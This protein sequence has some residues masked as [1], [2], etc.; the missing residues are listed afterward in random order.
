MA[1]NNAAYVVLLIAV[2]TKGQAKYP[3]GAVVPA[4][5]MIDPGGDT[6]VTPVIDPPVI[7]TEL[8]F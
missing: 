4:N 5:M 7:A 2:G 8:A 1:A 6:P 3:V